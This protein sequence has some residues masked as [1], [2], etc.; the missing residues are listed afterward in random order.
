MRSY[1][2]LAVV[3]LA[4]SSL[5]PVFSAPTVRSRYGNPLVEFTGGAFLISGIP[6][7]DSFGIWKPD[8]VLPRSVLS[9]STPPTVPRLRRV[10]RL[11]GL[12]SQA[13]VSTSQGPWTVLRPDGNPDPGW[14][15]GSQPP[16]QRPQ[17]SQ[18]SGPRPGSTTSVQG[19]P[20]SGKAPPP[21][22]LASKPK[23]TLRLNP[24]APPFSPKMK[25]NPNKPLNANAPEFIPRPATKRVLESKT[26]PVHR[27]LVDR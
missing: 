19:P 18:A 5:C 16:I 25:L 10:G 7:F 9:S 1:I 14:T 24:N 20:G 3:A 11:A 2:N 27:D 4:A 13:P 22:A 12:R 17:L 23:S 8:E 15:P 26:P 6:I 21:P